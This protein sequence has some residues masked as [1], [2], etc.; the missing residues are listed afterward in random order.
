MNLCRTANREIVKNVFE[1][2][3]D[4]LVDSKHDLDIVLF[5]WRSDHD[6]VRKLNAP[7]K[8]CIDLA[9]ASENKVAGWNQTQWLEQ[10]N[11]HALIECC[12]ADQK[13]CVIWINYMLNRSLAYYRHHVFL[14][15]PPWYWSDHRD[16]DLVDL[17]RQPQMIFLAATKN[18][19]NRPARHA[20]CAHLKKYSDRGYISQWPDA[21]LSPN[22][23]VNSTVDSRIT[24]RDVQGYRPIHNCFYQD[25]FVSIYCETL[26]Y[27]TT[28][29]VT[30]KTWDPLIKGH[31]VLPYGHQGL[32]QSLRE[33]G[34][35]L[36]SFIDYGY[37]D[38]PDTDRLSAYIAEIDRLLAMNL[39]Q[40]HQHW[41][42]NINKIQH[43]RTLLLNMPYHRIDFSDWITK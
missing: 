39:T 20:I 22:G 4:C 16:F 43:N 34:I 18:Y 21:M 3:G 12:A 40:W 33:I 42:D 36:P 32:V 11:S 2:N 9:H 38:L 15:G 37:D 19:D 14:S 6:Q 26:E 13:P 25:S 30:E 28:K 5:D 10:L 23:M 24:Y 7:L 31:F 41:L 1:L 27:G 8:L 29:L 35:Q 17:D